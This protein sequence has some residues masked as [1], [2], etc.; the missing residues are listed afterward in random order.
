[1]PYLLVDSAVDG[2]GGTYSE[3]GTA[4][5]VAVPGHSLMGKLILP[6]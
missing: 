5:S 4:S 1:V 3:P 6:A 2:P